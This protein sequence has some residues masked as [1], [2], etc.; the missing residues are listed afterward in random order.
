MTG[1]LFVLLAG[2]MAH[3]VLSP[4]Q[5]FSPTDEG[6]ILAG[7]R[8]IIDRQVPHRD[9][10]S[11]RPVLSLIL[12]TPELVLGRDRCLQLSRWVFWLEMA[13]I[14]W[15][16][17]GLLDVP[18]RLPFAVIAFV[19]SA[20]IFPAMAW[21]TVDALLLASAGISL[22]PSPIGYLLVGASV[23]CR[24]NF[25]LMLPAIAIVTREPAALLMLAPPVLYAGVVACLGGWRDM[26]EQ[27]RSHGARRAARVGVIGYANRWSALGAALGLTLVAQP[28]GPW[29]L[30]AAPLATA[31]LLA[32]GRVDIPAYAAFAAAAVVTVADPTMGSVLLI[33]LAW[34]ASLS[35]GYPWPALLL[36]PLVLISVGAGATGPWVWGSAAITTILI[37]LAR[38]RF[39]YRDQV[40]G[41]RRFSLGDVLPGGKGI[42]VSEP[43]YRLLEELQQLTGTITAEGRRFAV[44]PE[45]AAFWMRSSQANPLSS[46]WPQDTEIATGNL[47]SRL[48]DDLAR[49]SPIDVLVQKH[50]WRAPTGKPRAGKGRGAV[51]EAM[52]AM[53]EKVGEGEY[54][55]T[56][57]VRIG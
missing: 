52:P 12:H 50:W 3:L 14:A 44:I 56:W 32:R 38:R 8:R 1:V 46:D 7:A 21:H 17:T 42:R 33:A 39:P 47:R 22:L 51:V 24:Q 53:G 6:F 40:G 18:G 26:I 5:G 11:V 4:L 23:L 41:G 2:T 57:R 20:Q 45:P 54:L 16:W 9:F 28:T 49:A 36:G 37:A 31:P 10:V 13:G 15:L 25:A 43:A 19:L 27:V 35:I 55:E 29:L 34:C 30:A 48:A